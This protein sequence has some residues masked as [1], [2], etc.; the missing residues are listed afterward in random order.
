MGVQF[1]CSTLNWQLFDALIL[2]YAHCHHPPFTTVIRVRNLSWCVRITEAI[3]L[4]TTRLER[5]F[6]FPAVN[7]NL[8]MEISEAITSLQTRY[9]ETKSK[10]IWH[11]RFWTLAFRSSWMTHFLVFS[12]SVLKSCHT[13]FADCFLI[14]SVDQLILLKWY[15]LVGY[16]HRVESNCLINFYVF[17]LFDDKSDTCMSLTIAV[18][19]FWFLPS[20]ACH[21]IQLFGPSRKLKLD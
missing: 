5:S 10:V 6:N 12:F 14:K 3:V 11:I 7:R 20:S 9:E 15:S 17:Q 4:A 1:D 16:H 19:V 8:Q 2:I 13:N 18:H 21:K